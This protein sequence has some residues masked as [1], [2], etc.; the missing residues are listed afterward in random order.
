MREKILLGLD[1]LI[2]ID[3]SI[4]RILDK[5]QNVEYTRSA[6]VEDGLIVTPSQYITQLKEELNETISKRE[7]LKSKLIEDE[8]SLYEVYEEIGVSSE[9]QNKIA[10]ISLLIEL[11]D[12][13]NL[14]KG[15]NR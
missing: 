9:I 13:C 11:I 8:D 2:L 5:I 14:K 15:M 12:E 1:E 10:K 4:K 7:S 3:E 6:I